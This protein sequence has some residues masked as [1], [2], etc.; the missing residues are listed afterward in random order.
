[1]DLSPPIR[2]G[3]IDRAYANP[4]DEVTVLI[5]DSAKRVLDVGCSIGIMGEALQQK[6]CEVTG[7]EASP[8]LAQDARLRLRRVIEADVED[9]ARQDADPGGPFDCVVMADVL[10]HL[11]DPWSVVRWIA[12]YV[13]E[14]G[15]M[16]VSVPN[17]RHIHLFWSLVVRRRWPYR[18][19]GLFDRTHLRWFAFHNLDELLADTEFEIVQLC[20]SYRVL[21]APSGWDR[22]APRLGD[23][24]TLQFIF[25]AERSRASR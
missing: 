12:K 2:D 20:R 18:E 9:L 10:E 7:I 1:M 21:P 25:R 19:V 13:A 4:R 22:M 17:V 5:P 14:N 3:K 16:V 8:V 24:G 15:S 6:G 23:F 11:R